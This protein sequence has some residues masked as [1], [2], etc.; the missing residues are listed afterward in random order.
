MAPAS[1]FQ[2]TSASSCRGQ[3]GSEGSEEQRLALPVLSVC[4]MEPALAEAEVTGGAEGVL[5]DVSSALF[6]FL[7]FSLHL[8][9]LWEFLACCLT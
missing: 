1:A 5:E 9:A 8:E 3:K 7:P 2:S 4:P 6:A